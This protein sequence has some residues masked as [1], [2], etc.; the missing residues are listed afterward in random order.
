MQKK[1][2][3]EPSL[4]GSAEAAHSGASYTRTCPALSPVP[5]LYGA[6]IATRVP[7]EDIDTDNPK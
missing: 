5:S 2:P 1:M 6:L 3:S 4:F 7:S